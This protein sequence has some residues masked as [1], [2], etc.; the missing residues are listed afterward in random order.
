MIGLA[1]FYGLERLIKSHRSE[2]SDDEPTH[3]GVFW[4]HIAAFGGYNALI[5]YIL[6]NRDPAQTLE[7][8]WYSVAMALHFMVNDVA[9][10]HDHQQLFARSGRWILAAANHRAVRVGRIGRDRLYCRRSSSMC[11]RKNC[12]PSATAVS[13]SSSGRWA[14]RGCYCCCSPAA[15]LP[16]GLRISR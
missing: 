13:R 2:R 15:R 8:I 12:L 16:P 6:A 9:L 14:I 7:L 3:A 4:L 1:G 10:Q 5:G 11:S